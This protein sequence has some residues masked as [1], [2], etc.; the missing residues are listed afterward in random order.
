MSI[1][2]IIMS[3]DLAE[4]E[5]ELELLCLH[6]H[7]PIIRLIKYTVYYMVSENGAHEIN[8]SPESQ[9]KCC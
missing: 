3:C 4:L 2:Y 8:W 6:E 7:G 9:W 1:I 5:L